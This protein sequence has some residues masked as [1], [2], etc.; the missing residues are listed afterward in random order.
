[1]NLDCSSHALLHV[2]IGMVSKPA[3]ILCDL[4]GA[5]APL[6]HSITGIH[7]FFRRLLEPSF[8]AG[9]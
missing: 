9:F 8:A 6:F 4:R 7:G 5:E 3:L 1:M 2:F